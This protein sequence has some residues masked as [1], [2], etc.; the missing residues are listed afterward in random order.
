MSFSFGKLNVFAQSRNKD[1]EKQ[2]QMI[3]PLL[4]DK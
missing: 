3:A 1:L 4:K 2:Q